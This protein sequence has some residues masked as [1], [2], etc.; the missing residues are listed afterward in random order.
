M[1][2]P[3]LQVAEAVVQVE[4]A[5]PRAGREVVARAGHGFLPDHVEP[6]VGEEPRPG[7]DGQGQLGGRH[8]PDAQVGV[9]ADGDRRTAIA[10][11]GDGVR[12]GEPLGVQLV[13]DGGVEDERVARLRV[14][15][16]RLGDGGLRALEQRV[17]PEA[18]QP[19]RRVAERRFGDR[20]ALRDPV[21]LPD[22]VLHPVRPGHKNDPVGGGRRRVLRERLDQVDAGEAQRA[23][24][25]GHL[26]DGGR[27]VAELELVLV[28]GGC[29]HTL[30]V[31]L[32]RRSP[33]ARCPG[34]PQAHPASRSPR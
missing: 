3:L 23:D 34:C 24:S 4:R 19:V 25:G 20:Q 21:E 26:R 32:R 33:A 8:V 31:G 13:R 2:R 1:L 7:L 18:Q 11:V 9:G 27:Q 28:S 16:R 22:A 10:A 30:S 17:R 29:A 15:R 5:H 12:D 6:V 14:D